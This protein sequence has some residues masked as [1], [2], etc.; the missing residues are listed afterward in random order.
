VMTFYHCTSLTTINIGSGNNAYSS[1]NGVLYNKNKTVLHTYAAGKTETT[2]IIPGSVTSIGMGAFV[3]CKLTSVTIPD[4]VKGIGYIA[5]NACQNLTS[6]TFQG[7]IPSIGFHNEAGGGDL[8]AKF[9]A[10]NATNGTPGT[11]TRA[12]SSGTWTR[13]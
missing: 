2:F 7:T 4:S 12:G 9:Y 1:E 8:R 5:F 13:Q 10:D 11:Y 6:V 3:R